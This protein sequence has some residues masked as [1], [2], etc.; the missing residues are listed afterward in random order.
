MNRLIYTAYIHSIQT[1]D[2]NRWCK[3]KSIQFLMSIKFIKLAIDRYVVLWNYAL[4]SFQVFNMFNL[5]VVLAKISI[6]LSIDFE[7]SKFHCHWAESDAMMTHHCRDQK[8][9]LIHPLFSFILSWW[10]NRFQWSAWIPNY[11]QRWSYHWRSIRD[12]RSVKNINQT[13]MTNS[14]GIHLFIGCQNLDLLLLKNGH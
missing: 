1:T 12:T 7:H 8:W 14:N 4:S 10:V 3:L 5:V 2:N 9:T 11:D 6:S 13:V